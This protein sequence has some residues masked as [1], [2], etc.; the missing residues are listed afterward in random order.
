[1]QSD[2]QDALSNLAM[3]EKL[4]D[5]VLRKVKSDSLISVVSGVIFR[6]FI[7]LWRRFPFVLFGLLLFGALYLYDL[8]F[9][10]L[11]FFF[12][13]F[14]FLGVTQFSEVLDFGDVDPILLLRFSLD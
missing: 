7:F 13:N 4:D 12:L 9:I 3:F 10:I 11:L 14:I 1:M 5:L 8:F 6:L 2:F